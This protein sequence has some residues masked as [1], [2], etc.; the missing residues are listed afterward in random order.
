MTMTARRPPANGFKPGVSGNPKG[1]TPAHA[2]VAKL[3]ENI[4]AH[5]PEIIAKLV[6]SARAGDIAAARL[7]LERALPPM[8]PIEAPV[9]IDMTGATLTDKARAV[10]DAVAGENIGA[11]QA[12]HL[13]AGLG[14]VAKIIE[15][16]EL[17]ARVAAL[18]GKHAKP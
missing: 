10:I 6:D 16:D 3:R 18:E 1:R 15:T 5:V 4:A 17:A 12:A 8:K 9:T 7:L 13:L 11:G 2:R 14:S